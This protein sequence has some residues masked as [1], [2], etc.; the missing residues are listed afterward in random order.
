MYLYFGVSIFELSIVHYVLSSFSVCDQPLMTEDQTT[1]SYIHGCAKGEDVEFRPK[2]KFYEELRD[3]RKD[4]EIVM[5]FRQSPGVKRRRE[6][7]K[8]TAKVMTVRLTS[9]GGT[10]NSVA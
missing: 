6:K 8:V 3:P 1:V 7:A 9:D 4:R 2:Y 5:R 10:N